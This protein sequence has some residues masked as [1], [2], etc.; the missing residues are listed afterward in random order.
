[1]SLR[2]FA[3]RLRTFRRWPSLEQRLVRLRDLRAM[4]TAFAWQ[5]PPLLGDAHLTAFDYP[6]DANQRRLRDAEVLASVCRNAG[7]GHLLEIGTS[8]GHSTAIMARNAPG[9]TVHTVNI[10]PEEIRAGG[11]LTTHALAR[12]EIGSH[13]RSLGLANVRQ[14]FA[15]TATWVPDLPPLDVAFIDGC[16]DERFV[17]NDT[18]KILP[19][20]HPGSFVLWHDCNPDLDVRF[21]WIAEVCAAVDGLCERN[22]IVGPLWLVEDSWMMAYRLP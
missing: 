16:H 15:N 17:L 9:A 11:E 10:P 6:E 20:C 22:E 18:R 2:R 14:I 7:R 21:P 13:Y 8:R 1:M 3:K 12:D 4:M 19:L 5:E